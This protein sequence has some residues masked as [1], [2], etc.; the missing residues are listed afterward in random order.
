MRR[1]DRAGRRRGTRREVP[2]RRLSRAIRPGRPPL[3]LRAER[4]ADRGAG[5]RLP[6]ARALHRQA[7]RRAGEDGSGRERDPAHVQPRTRREERDATPRTTRRRGGTTSGAASTARSAGR[8]PTRRRRGRTSSHRDPRRLLDDG[9]TVELTFEKLIPVMQMQVGYNLDARD[10]KKV[11]GSVYLHDQLNREVVYPP[12][13]NSAHSTIAKATTQHPIAT[14]T[15][16]FRRQK[17]SGGRKRNEASRKGT[18]RSMAAREGRRESPSRSFAGGS[19]RAAAACHPRGSGRSASRNPGR[20]VWTAGA[21]PDRCPRASARRG[22]HHSNEF[23]SERSAVPAAT[24][25]AVG[26]GRRAFGP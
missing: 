25:C 1:R 9:R 16:Q 3:R 24:S 7:A 10:G 22:R 5:R 2:L 8:S 19:V 14:S 15:P 6:P 21:R 13:P 23:A 11:V 4:L 12:R 20:L 26:T 17:D 18:T